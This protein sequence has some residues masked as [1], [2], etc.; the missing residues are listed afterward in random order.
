MSYSDA[1]EISEYAIP[2][3]QWACG[4]GLLEGRTESSIAPGENA[5][6]AEV[7]VVLSRFLDKAAK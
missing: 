4:A 5:S 1:F 2:A 6:R 3:I 7:A